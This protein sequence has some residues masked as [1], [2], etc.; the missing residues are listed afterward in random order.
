M[1]GFLSDLVFPTAQLVAA[2]LL[3]GV[4]CVTRLNHVSDIAAGTEPEKRE[5]SRPAGAVICDMA[6]RSLGVA[7]KIASDELRLPGLIMRS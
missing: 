3:S 4:C 5:D 7:G 6:Y 1:I 2:F